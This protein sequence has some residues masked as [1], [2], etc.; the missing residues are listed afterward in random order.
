MLLEEKDYVLILVNGDDGDERGVSH[1]LDRDNLAFRFNPIFFILS[2][3]DARG[4][5]LFQGELHH[6]V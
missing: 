3:V 4:K 5:T 2:L 1:L 6:V